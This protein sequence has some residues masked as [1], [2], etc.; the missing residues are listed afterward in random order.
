MNTL[1][2]GYKNADRCLRRAYVGSLMPKP[3]SLVTKLDEAFYP[4]IGE[5][6]DDCLFRQFILPHVTYQTS[7][8]DL[9]AGSGRILQMNFRG[10]VAKVCGIDLDPRVTTNPLLDEAKL[11]DGSH[12]PYPDES[13]DIVVADNVVEHIADPA[14]VFREVGRVLK[15]G[16]RF[17]F[18]TPNKHHYMPLI[19]RITPHSFHRLINRLRGRDETQTFPTLYRA[20]CRSDVVRIASETGFAVASLQRI[21]GRPEYMRLAWPLYLLGIAYERIVNRFAALEPFRIVLMVELVKD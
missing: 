14:V 20:N 16:G 7:M 3:R 9:G 6:W 19:A 18:K 15:P 10:V 5:R 8:L 21:E 17:L 12:I 4:G 2:M 1:E 11:T 13:F